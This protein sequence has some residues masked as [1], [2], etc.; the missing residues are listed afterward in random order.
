MCSN[1]HI[2]I[3][4]NIMFLAWVVSLLD[5]TLYS[6]LTRLIMVLL[7]GKF[8]CGQWICWERLHWIVLRGPIVLFLSNRIIAAFLCYYHNPSNV[9]NFQLTIWDMDEIALPFCW[10]H[11][12]FGSLDIILHFMEELSA[13]RNVSEVTGWW[14]FWLS[15]SSHLVGLRWAWCY[16]HIVD[17]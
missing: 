1:I 17:H 7:S 16:W 3:Q 14:K 15:W 6:V 12:R 13:K 4:G 9:F 2:R 8:T 5:G 10:T 11:V